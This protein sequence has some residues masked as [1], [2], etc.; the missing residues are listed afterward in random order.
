[1]MNAAF[2]ALGIDARM[3]A[4]AVAPEVLATE[5]ARLRAIPMLGAS[6]T[7][8]HK[9]AVAKLCDELA[10][11]AEETGAVN[12][13]VMGG[14]LVGHNT[15]VFGFQDALAECGFDMRGTH[16]V[17]LGAGGSARAIDFALRN[18]GATVDVAA[19]RPEAVAWTRA[20]AW[21]QLPSRMARADLLVDCSPTGLDPAADAAFVAELPLDALRKDAMVATL[22]YHRRTQLLDA[23]AARGQRTMDGRLM[24]IHQAAHAFALW[25]GQPA[26][27]D[28]MTRA[29]DDAMKTT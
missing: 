5:V 9:F 13:L 29:F 2:A 3:D 21:E 4:I 7:V 14:T 19:R 15:D 17:V 10:G 8:P 16:A 20:Y 12:C 1:M 6:V 26:P 22:V 25:T 18:G 11:A 23:A 28:I 24:L 27:I